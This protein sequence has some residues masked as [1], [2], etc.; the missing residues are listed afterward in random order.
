LHRG[1]SH[2]TYVKFTHSHTSH[3]QVDKNGGNHTRGQARA[4]YSQCVALYSVT[5]IFAKHRPRMQYQ[6]TVCLSRKRDTH[7]R[8]SPPLFRLPPKQYLQGYATMPPSFPLCDACTRLTVELPAARAWLQ[9]LS[10]HG[11][12]RPAHPLSVCALRHT[13]RATAQRRGHRHHCAIA[14]SAPL[15]RTFT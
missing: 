11:S 8:P 12:R 13:H 1:T 3:N 14:T 15:Q 10:Q 5:C 7:S 2:P 6:S 9:A 4:L